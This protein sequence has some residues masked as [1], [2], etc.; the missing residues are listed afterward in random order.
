MTGKPCSNKEA[1]DLTRAILGSANA[2]HPKCGLMERYMALIPRERADL[3]S[4]EAERR[5]ASS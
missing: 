3:I 1:R 2:A 5:R 4:Q